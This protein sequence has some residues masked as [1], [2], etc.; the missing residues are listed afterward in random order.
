MDHKNLEYFHTSK[1]LNQ[2]QARWSLHLSRFDFMLHHHPGC[3]MGK[4]NALSC[5]ADHGSRGRDN[6]DM[7][8]LP[9]SLFSICTLEGVAAIRAEAEVL[10]DIQ[11]EFHD[12]EKEDSVVK[13]VEELQKGHSRLVQMVEWSESDGLLHFHGKIYIPD[14]KDL[15]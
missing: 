10:Q 3:S 2:Q 12:G 15:R 11:K 5:H 14:G 1:K 6:A 13:A 4:S 9:P 8:M 7:T